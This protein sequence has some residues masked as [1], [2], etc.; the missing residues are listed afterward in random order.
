[1]ESSEEEVTIFS[2]AAAENI[3]ML[4]IKIQ[5]I[6]RLEKDCINTVICWFAN[7]YMK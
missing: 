3:R 6:I 2:I 7:S 4:V 1:M 5:M